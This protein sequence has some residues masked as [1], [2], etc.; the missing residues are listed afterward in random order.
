MAGPCN[1]PVS[2]A[3]CSNCTALSTLG[4]EERAVFEEMAADYLWNWTLQQYGVCR[5]V[6]RPCRANCEGMASFWGRGPGPLVDHT[7]GLVSGEWYSLTCG[8]CANANDSCGCDA[9]STM[10]LPGPVLSVY[11]VLIDGAVLAPSAYRQDNH[12]V[13]TRVDGGAWPTCQSMKLP[14]TAAGTWA[15]TYD[16][17]TPVPIGGQIAAGVLACELA[18]AACR[19]STC[20]LPQ[21]L[22]TITRQGVTMAMIDTFDDLDKGYTGIWVIDS[23]VAS[24][25]KP[26]PAARVFSPDVSRIKGRSSRG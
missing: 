9:P 24:V 22:Q 5:V 8:R 13:L 4:V 6:V 26:K 3:G 16:R 7:S 2:Y 18:K 12:D 21:R 15:V 19:D 1:W 17:G 14:T 10:K 25:T 11:E 23:W 20:A